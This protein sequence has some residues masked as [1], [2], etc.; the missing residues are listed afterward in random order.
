VNVNAIPAELRDLPRW[1]VWRWEPDPAKP[2]KPRKPP[3]RV[4]DHDRHASSTKPET[5]GTFAQ[6]IAVVEAGSAD[7]IGFA[8]EP[9]FVGID[10]DEDLSQVDQYAV[11]LVLDSYS[12]RSPSGD[13][14]HVVIRAS[15]NGHGRHPQGIGVFQTDRFFY[16][17]GDHVRGTPTT[18]EE[19]QAQLDDVLA[20][21]LPAP[22]VDRSTARELQPVDLGDQELIDKALGARNG[23]DFSALWNG[24]TSGYDDDHSRADLALCG[25]LAFWTG[26]DADR[27]DRMFRASGLFREK[28]NRD[29]Y[30]E[31]TI[32]AA[33]IGCRDVY[34][35]L[36]SKVRPASDAPGTH[37]AI[38]PGDGAK[39]VGA[40]RVPYVVGTQ[41][42]DAPT[43]ASPVVMKEPLHAEEAEAFAAVEE[44]SAEP[45]LGDDANTV[46][47]AGGAAVYYGDGGAGKTTLG[48]DRACHYCAGRDWLGLPV[49]RPLRV[50]WIENEGPRG[51]FRVKVRAKL[52]A[53]DGP[54]LEGRLHVLSQPWARFTFADEQMRAELV[55]IIRTLEI[56]VVIAGPVARLGAEGGGTPKEIQAFIDLLEL[57]RADLGRPLAYELIHHENKAG[58]VSGAWEG[59]TDTLAHVQARGNGHT[60]IVWRKAR[61]APEIHGKTWKLNWRDGEQF[62]LDETPETTDDEIAEK[63][64]GLVR[65]APG[66]S[67]NSYDA[68]LAGQ[69]TRKRAIRDEL[70][71]DGRLVN[72]GTEKSMRLFLP[73]Q[74]DETLFEATA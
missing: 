9:P 15:L 54:P 56:D 22:Q 58:G 4:D 28:W 68:L 72:E 52:A 3:Y 18:I 21:F 64:L 37:P 38:S 26:R 32:D 6:A 14:H 35:P 46:L 29:D 61:W 41:L 48:L 49:S 60:A 59:A 57:V 33:I 11:M 16:F 30:R 66:G 74:T 40:S 39:S 69:A 24:D 27:I 10:L 12:E 13:G 8:L 23:S 19:R 63:L 73:A 53:W 7:G 62:E 2:D 25:L 1:V 36:Q 55:A 67:W 43:D 65:E 42:R 31:R 50:L 5:W 34:E 20:R 70:L 44:A 17:T 45:L 71:T 47:A 51:K